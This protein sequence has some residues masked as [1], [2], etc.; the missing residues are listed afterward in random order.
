VR[1]EEA[2]VR[3]EEACDT[4]MMSLL[5]SRIH[6]TGAVAAIGINFLKS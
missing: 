6:K 5:L 1:F 2:C 4:F 3:F